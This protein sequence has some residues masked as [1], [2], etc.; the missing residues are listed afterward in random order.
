MADILATNERQTVELAKLRSKNAELKDE[1][2][3]LLERV[4]RESAYDKFCEDKY[5]ELL[6][7]AQ[8]MQ[9][10]YRAWRD[11]STTYWT[12]FN[13]HAAGM[14]KLLAALPGD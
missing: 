5:Y 7:H 11:D 6:A 4:A 2:T 13:C 1:V 9:S 14:P 3:R 10:E 12:R 8:T